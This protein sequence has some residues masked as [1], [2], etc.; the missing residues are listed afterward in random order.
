MKY[1]SLKNTKISLTF[2][3]ALKK[4]LS[5]DRGLFFP[6]IIPKLPK[7]F[8]QKIIKMSINDIA[9][10]IIKPYIGESIDNNTLLKI[11]DSTL[12]FNF[13]LVRLSKNIYT[14][15]LFHGPTLAFKDVGAR[16]MA[17]CMESFI[18]NNQKIFLLQYFIHSIYIVVYIINWININTTH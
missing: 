15:E 3:Q 10:E 1:Y 4:G 17:K 11:V 2:S 18:G 13:P 16:F 9:L 8:F 12:N 7:S 6:K 14:L 5:D